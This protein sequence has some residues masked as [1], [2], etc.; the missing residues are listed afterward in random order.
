MVNIFIGLWKVQR[1]KTRSHEFSQHML[2]LCVNINSLHVLPVRDTYRFIYIASRILT[3][4]GAQR[5]FPEL[6]FILAMQ[7]TTFLQIR[8]WGCESYW[9]VNIF[10]NFYIM[11]DKTLGQTG[12]LAMN[13]Y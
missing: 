11:A 3:F 7:G 5:I 12:T 1:L 9:S 2:L 4:G 6:C 8:I 13:K 10:Q